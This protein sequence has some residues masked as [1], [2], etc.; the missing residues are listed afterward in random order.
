VVAAKVEVDDLQ[1]CLAELEQAT[2]W[3]R[4]ED[5]W[6]IHDIGD[7]QQSK[8]E[9][10]TE[11]AA[12]RERIRHVR[13]QKRERANGHTNGSAEGGSADVREKFAGSSPEQFPNTER[14]SPEVRQMFGFPVPGPGPVGSEDPYPVPVPERARA[15]DVA[16]PR[17]AAAGDATGDGSDAEPP[18]AAEERCPMC[19]EV[20]PDRAALRDHLDNSPRH[21]VRPAPD[22]TI[23]NAVPRPSSSRGRR[24]AEINAAE[25]DAELAALA[26]RTPLKPADLPAD[27][28][29]EHERLLARERERRERV[30]ADS[31]EQEA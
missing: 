11:R 20:F 1:A 3:V 9:V 17:R 6:A 29:A 19:P 25:V 31:P 10:E 23:G 28:L 14:S 15:P 22:P 4:T 7:Y 2:R 18:L 26:S 24:Q 30:A 27:V 21:K 12:A 5:G 16:A 8:A 13:E